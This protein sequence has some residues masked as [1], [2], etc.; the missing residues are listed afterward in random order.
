MLSKLSQFTVIWCDNVF[1]SVINLSSRNKISHIEWNLERTRNYNLS[2]H[3]EMMTTWETNRNTRLSNSTEFCARYTFDVYLLSTKN[4]EIYNTLLHS[5]VLLVMI[6]V[7]LIKHMWVSWLGH[8]YNRWRCR[9]KTMCSCE[10]KI[11]IY[12]AIDFGRRKQKQ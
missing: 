11:V 9:G 2:A 12:L 5:I 4:F 8:F 7:L 3:F 1:I 10:P 6:M